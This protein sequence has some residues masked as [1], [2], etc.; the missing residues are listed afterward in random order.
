M[1]W[2]ETSRKTSYEVVAGTA[3]SY[4]APAARPG[5]ALLVAPG[6]VHHPGTSRA[7]HSTWWVI[8]KTYM[9][10]SVS[11]LLCGRLHS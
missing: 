1:S 2:M 6:R 3:T 8:G 9:M 10:L 7:T 11:A 5:R 4:D